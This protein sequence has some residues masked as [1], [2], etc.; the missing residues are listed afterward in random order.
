M[1]VKLTPT[2]V[3]NKRAL[4][5]RNQLPIAE[6]PTDVLLFPTNSGITLNP[7][8]RKLFTAPQADVPT[9]MALSFTTPDAKP[10]TD[11]HA[12]E[13]DESVNFWAGFNRTNKVRFEIETEPNTALSRLR[14]SQ[15]HSYGA[16]AYLSLYYGINGH[17]SMLDIFSEAAP[18]A[19]ASLVPTFHDLIVRNPD[20]MAA[21]QQQGLASALPNSASYR[22]I[23]KSCIKSARSSRNGSDRLVE[24]ERGARMVTQ[25]LAERHGLGK[26]LERHDKTSE[27]ARLDK[28]LQ[29]AIDTAK[30]PNYLSAAGDSTHTYFMSATSN[31]EPVFQQIRQ[32]LVDIIP[33]NAQ[34]VNDK[35]LQAI[36][37]A[38]VAVG[39][40][41]FGRMLTE[42][43]ERHKE[44]TSKIIEVI[45]AILGIEPH[46]GTVITAVATIA[47]TI[48]DAVYE[49]KTDKVKPIATLG[50]RITAAFLL[51]TSDLR[52]PDPFIE[53]EARGINENERRVT[54]DSVFYSRI[55]SAIYGIA[56]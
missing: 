11:L 55:L 24:I 17:S 4:R 54:V 41:N 10:I 15:L 6:S 19:V 52:F 45:G 9:Q 51:D 23:I 50:Q 53:G 42:R 49:H 37:V 27:E 36:G 32:L 8:A 3:A 29:R 38:V 30:R 40:A 7:N 35:E 43:Y 18:S 28:E 39:V 48:S 5:E 25:F 26:Y 2:H 21:Q 1:P 16:A 47:K 22:A 31:I 13:K 46:A 12:R 56:Y 34:S 33:S 20:P 44:R 14:N